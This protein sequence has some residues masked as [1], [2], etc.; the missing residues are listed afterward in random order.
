MIMDMEGRIRTVHRDAVYEA[1]ESYIREE[2]RKLDHM[3]HRAVSY[4]TVTPL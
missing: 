3:H 2:T 4:S 1:H